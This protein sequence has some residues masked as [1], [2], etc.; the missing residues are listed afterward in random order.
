MR[1][2]VAAQQSGIANRLKS[3]ANY[4]PALSAI[5]QGG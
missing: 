1:N 4:V 5:F 2:G 3:L